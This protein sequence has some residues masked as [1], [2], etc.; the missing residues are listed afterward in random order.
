MSETHDKLVDCIVAL[1]CNTDLLAQ[2]NGDPVSLAKD[3]GV[4]G[5]DLQLIIN[6]D[7]DAIRARMSEAQGAQQ[8]YV[9][10]FHSP[11]S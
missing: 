2:Y 10:T 1:N 3:Y 5:D 4:E 7:F 6:R 9:I 8:D 11:N